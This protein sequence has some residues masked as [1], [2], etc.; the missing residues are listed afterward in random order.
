MELNELAP[1]ICVY[2]DNTNWGNE[3]SNIIN[4]YLIDLFVP[5]SIVRNYEPS[6][7][8]E[9]R[10]CKTL[11]LNSASSCHP[12]DFLFKIQNI[13]TE[14]TNTCISSFRRRYWV[15]EVDKNHQWILLNYGTEDYFKYH[16]DDCFTYPRTLSVV[17]YLNDDYEGGEIDF[18]F[19]NISYKPKSGDILL[20][21][22]AFPYM[23]EVK[24]ITKGC[25]N[26]AVT[27]YSYTKL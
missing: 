23:H 14:K 10:K 13:L 2:N 17:I 9:Y 21:S 6:V 3:Y 18:K 16:N 7:D 11:D 22:S 15:D 25:R 27:W 26:A 20:F 12:D 24:P 5:G 1:G 4:S 8:I 19:F